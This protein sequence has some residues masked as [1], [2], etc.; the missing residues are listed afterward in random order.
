MNKFSRTT[1]SVTF[2][3][4]CGLILTTGAVGA[5]PNSVLVATAQESLVNNAAGISPLIN[6]DAKGSLTIHK[7][8][9]PLNTGKPTGNK[10]DA[11]SGVGLDGVGFTVYKIKDID[12][13]SN[14]GLAAAAGAKAE[15]YY[16]NGKIVEQGKLEMIAGGEQITKGGG[17]ITFEGLTP[18]AY[19]VVETKPAENYRPAAPFI[20]FVPMTQNNAETGGTSWNYDVHAYPKNY[21]EKKPEKKVE[22]SGK[23]AGDK[24]VYTVTAYA[25]KIDKN[26]GEQ[27]SKFIVEDI[28]DPKLTAPNS[29]EV[30]VEGFS[31]G[32]Y[33]VEITG[34]KVTVSL[35]KT[36][37]DKLENDQVVKVKIPAV[38]QEN[39]NGTIPNTANV[40]QNVPNSEEDKKT[41]TNEVKTYYGGV[42]FIKVSAAD[43][44][45]K[46][47]GAEFKVFGVKEDQT[48]DKESV[49]GDKQVLEQVKVNG[50][51]QTYKSN[52]DGTVTISGLHVNDYANSTEGTPNLYKSYCLV[53]TKS[54]KGYE[55]FAAPIS[56]E[57]KKSEVEGKEDPIRLLSEVG[58]DG[59]LKN[60]EDTTPNLPMTG[61][62]GI[63]ILAALGALIIGAGAW[64]ARRNSAKN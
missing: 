63:G 35:T 57:I 3:A 41:T 50:V 48:C 17:D 30:T 8:G 19:L 5:T 29:D 14:A 34:Q 4:M 47:E 2:A 44:S 28:L 60:L 62:A 53:E 24:I 58:Q 20:A 15:N 26:V 10:D 61:G 45:Q 16:K 37:L 55:L 12:L 54:P 9:D 59:K 56:F 43:T 6:K 1:R 18:A 25:Q 23:N 27:R 22:D 32:D 38:V 52:V 39:F 51:S 49:D 42:K 21:S 33:T 13:T 64:L 40:I 11:V 31:S 46:L 7:K 36:G